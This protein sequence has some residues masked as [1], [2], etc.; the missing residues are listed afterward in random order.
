MP[1]KLTDAEIV[2]ALECCIIKS[3]CEGCP[4]KKDISKC[5]ETACKSAL[6][7]INRLQAEKEVLKARIGVYETCN[8][9]KDEAN[10]HLEAENERLKEE[11]KKQQGKVKI[12]ELIINK[13]KTGRNAY[14]DLMSDSLGYLEIKAEAYKECIEKVKEKLRKL[15]NWICKRENH[16]NYG[17]SYDDVFH[18]LDNL[19]KELVGEDK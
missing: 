12:R 3:S 6:D 1:D 13:L 15:P 19:L 17:F 16:T 8:A 4:L 18:A 7:L 5:L 10:R 14:I 2:K 9:R 11:V